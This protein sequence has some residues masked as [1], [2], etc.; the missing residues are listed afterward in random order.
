MTKVVIPLLAAR[1]RSK[2]ALGCMYACT[3]S[4]YQGSTKDNM[5]LTLLWA[6]ECSHSNLEGE[7]N[8]EPP[9][10]YFCQLSRLNSSPIGWTILRNNGALPFCPIHTLFVGLSHSRT[11]EPRDASPRACLGRSSN[12]GASQMHNPDLGLGI[13][14]GFSQNAFWGG[15]NHLVHIVFSNSTRTKACTWTD[16]ISYP[17]IYMLQTAATTT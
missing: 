4:N 6:T 16:S 9:S 3:P 17:Y 14:W 11:D 10:R 5:V 2:S 8:G 12:F 13:H 15:N 7:A 1:L